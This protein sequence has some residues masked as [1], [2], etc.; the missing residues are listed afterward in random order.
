MEND[1]SHCLFCKIV[2]GT[3]PAAIV[4]QDDRLVAF[5]DINPQAPM[6]L[7]VVPRRHI[8]TTNDLTGDDDSLLG[9]MARR[10]SALAAAHGWDG[11]AIRIVRS[12]AFA[13]DVMNLRR[14]G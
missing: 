13:G 11:D 6:H 12:A 8:A 14:A 7:L 4:Y 10:A 2:E 9:E 3:I 5:K 1:V